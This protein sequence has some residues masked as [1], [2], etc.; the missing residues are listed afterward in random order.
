[1]AE[2]QTQ[3]VQRANSV[4]CMK[5]AAISLEKPKALLAALILPPVLLLVRF[6]AAL[7][8]ETRV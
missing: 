2:E 1:M 5:D 8:G 4:G 7:A 6:P 3:I